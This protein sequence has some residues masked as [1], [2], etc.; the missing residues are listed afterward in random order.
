[1]DKIFAYGTPE[2]DDKY[3]S[4][5]YI[6]YA[7]SIWEEK[8]DEKRFEKILP[9]TKKVKLKTFD[10]KL[11]FGTLKVAAVIQNSDNSDKKDSQ[12]EIAK[13]SHTLLKKAEE[14][15]ASA[16]F[17]LIEFSPYLKLDLGAEFFKIN[18]DGEFDMLKASA[19]LS[20]TL[21]KKQVKETPFAEIEDKMPEDASL[22]VEIELEIDLSIKEAK[23]LSLLKVNEAQL[24]ALDSETKK[25]QSEIRELNAE[26]IKKQNAFIDKE[27][28]DIK[29]KDEKQKKKLIE[30]LEKKFNKQNKQIRESID[31]LKD[32]LRKQKKIVKKLEQDARN[33]SDSIKSKFLKKL[34]NS[35]IK[36]CGSLL[37]KIAKALDYI[38]IVFSVLK[39][40][41]MLWSGAKMRLFKGQS[42]SDI[43]LY[44]ISEILEQ[45]MLDKILGKEIPEGDDFATERPEAVYPNSGN[46]SEEENL[47]AIE[48]EYQNF[49]SLYGKLMGPYSSGSGTG[50]N[51]TLKTGN[52]SDGNSG[53]GFSKKEEKEI[54]ES[55][56][57]EDTKF[58]TRRKTEDTPV[59]DE[60]VSEHKDGIKA[61]KIKKPELLY[62]QEGNY[63]TNANGKEIQNVKVI[64]I[65]N[66]TNSE[67]DAI[68]VDISFYAYAKGAMQLFY[69]KR[70]EAILRLN[71]EE[72]KVYEITKS[73]TYE[74]EGGIKIYLKKES[75][76]KNE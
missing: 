19:K 47:A 56:K 49:L 61:S 45:T 46:L 9:A 41:I 55:E 11:S 15:F 12:V 35:F 54:E 10:I 50:I 59:K 34:N 3:R 65:E 18:S 33:I 72:E 23:A 4:N 5:S 37:A 48:A 28:K 14:S 7:E 25:I 38:E 57:K 66:P 8:T 32:K 26:K 53:S 52:N 2:E 71:S 62:S 17:T 31:N 20:Q 58:G 60:K 63:L 30:K 43:S 40:S 73:V 27:L 29:F 67:G 21:S 51:G 69:F 16:N 39:I 44:E 64:E 75:K 6:N 22:I 13:F 42:L 70:V 24:D 36:K 74:F 68:M 76:F 1:M